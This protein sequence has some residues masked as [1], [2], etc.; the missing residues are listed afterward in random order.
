MSMY[1]SVSKHDEV[2]ET[3]DYQKNLGSST[4]I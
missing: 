4:V 2:W 3:Q 1:N